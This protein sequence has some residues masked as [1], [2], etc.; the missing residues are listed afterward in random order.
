[1]SLDEFK[2]N[3]EVAAES[4]FENDDKKSFKREKGRFEFALFINDFLICKRNFSINGYVEKSMQTPEF[5]NEVDKKCS[6]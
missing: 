1:M 5:K 6:L 4:T 3:A 2:E